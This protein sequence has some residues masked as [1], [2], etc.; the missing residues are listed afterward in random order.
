MGIK[1]GQNILDIV[2]HC[3]L[4][5]GNP[6]QPWPRP[7]IHFDPTEKDILRSEVKLLLELG[8]IEAALHS[9]D[10]YVSTILVGKKKRGKYR[11]ILKNTLRN[12][13]LKWIPFG[14]LCDSWL[15]TVSWRH[16]N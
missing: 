10:E 8:V 16:L 1:A 9:P 4:E 11:M 5:I 13:I 12:I 15:Q 2:Q 14:Q 3:H 7:E 6:T